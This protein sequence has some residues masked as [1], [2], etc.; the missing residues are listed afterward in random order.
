LNGKKER[1][2]E[3]FRD[4]A[5]KTCGIRTVNEAMIVGERKRQNQTRLEFPPIHSGS[6]REREVQEWPPR[7]D[8]DGRKRRAPMP[9]RL[10]MVMFPPSISATVI[11]FSRAFC[12]SCDN[13]N[14]QLNNISLIHIANHWNQ[15]N[16]GRIACHPILMYCL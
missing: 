9:P 12:D 16:R 6:I 8:H 7:D 1:L 13:S 11:F 14:R 2:L 3:S 10:V 15:Q 5:Q 4:P